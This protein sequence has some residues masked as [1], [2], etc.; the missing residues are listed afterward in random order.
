MND[1]TPD[2]VDVQ[3]PVRALAWT[4]SR[5]FVDDVDELLEAQGEGEVIL[6]VTDATHGRVFGFVEAVEGD[7][8]LAVAGRQDRQLL[9]LYRVTARLVDRVNGGDR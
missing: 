4:P 8:P 5:G 6:D 1:L 3:A 9:E 2:P 7:T